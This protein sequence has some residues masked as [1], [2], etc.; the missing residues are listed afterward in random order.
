MNAIVVVDENWAIGKDGGLLVHL[1][2]DLKYYKEKTK[3][4][5]IVIGRKT[6]D[7]FPGSKPLPDRENIVLTGNRDFSAPGCTVLNSMAQ[8]AVY[9]GRFSE[10]DIFVSG[11]EIIYRRFMPLCDT[12]YVTHIQASFEGAD[13]HFTD[14]D[15]EEDVA[16][17]WRSDVREENGV[18]YY[19]AKYERK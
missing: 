14:L 9:L 1:P 11:G 3:G 15:E 5:H 7:S 12:F 2:G 18:R 17:T 13:K 19:F 6:L 16:E 10:D 4:K 8:A